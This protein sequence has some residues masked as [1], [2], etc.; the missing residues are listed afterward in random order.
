MTDYATLKLKVINNRGRWVCSRVDFGSAFDQLRMT[1]IERLYLR[2][3]PIRKFTSVLLI[4][5]PEQFDAPRS[6][7]LCK[8][9]PHRRA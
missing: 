6:L 9:Q 1:R 7:S 3:Q 5:Y 4:R 2:R 8:L